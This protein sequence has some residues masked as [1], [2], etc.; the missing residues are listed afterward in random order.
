MAYVIKIRKT[1][2]F[3]NWLS[4][5]RVKEQAQIDS[6]LLRIQEFGHFGD[7][8]P[9]KGSDFQLCELRWANGPLSKLRFC[10][11]SGSFESTFRLFSRG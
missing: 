2:E 4:G 5:L 1:P 9:L 3:D 10:R 7:F 11:F 8:K 6:R